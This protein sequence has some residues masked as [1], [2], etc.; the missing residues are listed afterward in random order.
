MR[1]IALTLLALA[2]LAGI[3]AWTVWR[4][5]TVPVSSPP[6]AVQ[7]GQQQ[8]HTQLQQ[9]IQQESGIEKQAWNS[10]DELVKLL[11]WHQQRIDR[12]TGNP[13]ASEVLSYDH[14]SIVRIQSRI[15]E[16]AAEEKVK[17][18]A[19]IEQAKEDAIKA[20]EEATQEKA[21]RAAAAAAAQKGIN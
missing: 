21:Q 17:E 18:L 6:S 12:L 14:D 1:I 7:Q 5:D 2:A 8:L 10:T 20:K 16:L 13:Q 3:I 19:A 15:N 4:A 11:H 9:T